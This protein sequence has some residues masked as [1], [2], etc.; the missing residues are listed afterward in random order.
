MIRQSPEANSLAWQEG[1]QRLESAIRDRQS[2]AFESTLGGNTIPHLIDQAAD[3]GMEV[4]VW[5]TRAPVMAFGPRVAAALR[6]SR[7]ARSL[8]SLKIEGLAPASPA[9]ASPMADYLNGGSWFQ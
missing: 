7:G 9:L 8:P 5:F 4:L 6:P 3:A 1:K 2:F